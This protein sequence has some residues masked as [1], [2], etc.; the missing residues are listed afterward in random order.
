M[1][2]P[3]EAKCGRYFTTIKSMNSHL[4][5]AKS[6]SWFVE[7][8]L[9]GLGID[10]DL[11]SLSGSITADVQVDGDVEWEGWNDSEYDSDRQDQDISMEFGPDGD[12]FQ[13]IPEEPE[14]IEGNQPPQNSSSRDSLLDDDDDDRITIVDENAGWIFRKDPPRYNEVDNEGD[15]LMGEDC[16]RNPFEPFS[17]ELDWMVAHWAVKDGPGHNAFNRFLEIPGV[18]NCDMFHSVISILSRLL[19]SL[20]FPITTLEVFIK[21]WTLFLKRLANGRVKSLASMT[22]RTHL[23]YDIGILLLPLKVFGRMSNFLKRWFTLVAKFF[24]TRRR[25]IEFFQKC[26]QG[27]YGMDYR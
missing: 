23:Q 12:V 15:T 27:N 25:R 16:I 4:T 17:S 24:R 21:S 14:E 13:F 8:K 22:P 3:C 10:D 9:R 5:S 18:S 6:C 20:A 2:H 7:D 11:V 19:R 26:G 1:S